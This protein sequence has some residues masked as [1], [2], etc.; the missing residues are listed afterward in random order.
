MLNYCKFQGTE[1][2]LSPRCFT[3]KIMRIIPIK[4]ITPVKLSIIASFITTFLSVA[5]LFITHL[6]G[7]K[8]WMLF[9]ILF[10]FATAYMT[11]FYVLKILID[12][13][14]APIYKTIREIP[15]K[16]NEINQD[17]GD[18]NDTISEVDI[19]VKMWA[20]DK[21]AEIDRLR[22]LEK[23]RKDLIGNVSH[24]LKTPIFNIQGYVLTLLDGGIEDP[25][26]NR[27]YLER[28]EKSIDRMI[29]IVEDLESIT[30]L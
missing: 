22:D 15:Y 30:K 10:I 24:E 1:P 18:K 12:E 11:T 7:W 8:I 6:L 3:F 19:D 5:L 29:S 4:S 21:M 16:E 23:Y 26:I 2:D 17:G 13:K 25:K 9:F 20:T 28:T 14:I 27:R